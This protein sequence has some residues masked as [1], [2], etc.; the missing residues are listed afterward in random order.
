MLERI[1]AGE[2][3]GI[4]AWHQTAFLETRWTLRR[5][6]TCSRKGVIKDLKFGSYTYDQFSRGHHDA[7]DGTLAITVLFSQV[8]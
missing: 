2:A 5:S 7:P 3:D 6:P 8:E 4:I 1:K